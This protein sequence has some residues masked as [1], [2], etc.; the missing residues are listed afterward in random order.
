MYLARQ[1]VRE[2]K[3]PHS[4]AIIS[5][6]RI[7]AYFVRAG[8]LFLTC[9]CKYGYDQTCNRND[10]HKHLIITHK[11]PLLSRLRAGNHSSST[12][13]LVKY[14]IQLL[15]HITLKSNGLTYIF[16]QLPQDEIDIYICHLMFLDI[17]FQIFCFRPE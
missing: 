17:F 8:R 11:H 4:G 16:S 6:I 9:V 14:T 10:Y 1:P 12:G 3:A 13:C 7:A 5:Y 2:V 15:P